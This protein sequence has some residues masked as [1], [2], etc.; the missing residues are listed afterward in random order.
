MRFSWR[1]FGMSMLLTVT[2]SGALSVIANALVGDQTIFGFPLRTIIVLGLLP[3]LANNRNLAGR[4][5]EL[6]KL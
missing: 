5:L 1:A 2:L 6:R 3:S 4:A